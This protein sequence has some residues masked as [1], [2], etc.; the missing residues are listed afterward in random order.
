MP[1]ERALSKLGAASRSRTREMILAGKLKVNGRVIT[2]PAFHVVPETD[3][4]EMD[5]ERVGQSPWRTIVLNKPKGYV[6]T[7]R[8]E[9]GRKTI[10]DLLPE[11][12]RHLHPVGRLDMHTTGLL[13]LTTDTRLSAHLTDPANGI[14]RTYVVTVEGRVEEAAVKRLLKGIR[15]GGDVLKA[16]AI[17]VRKTSGRES[18]MTVTLTEGKNREIRRMFK[19]LG[20]EVTALKRIAFGP[21]VLGDLASG[22]YRD[23]NEKE[24]RR[25]RERSL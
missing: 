4:F 22:A 11:E 18:H 24:L 20:H 9:R 23:V 6:T 17:A 1:L 8:D 13:I 3:R 5:G 7:A 25:E 16:D 12:L 15:D 21:L 10:Y 2:D 14:D 19:A